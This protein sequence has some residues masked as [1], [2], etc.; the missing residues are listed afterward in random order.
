MIH[1]IQYLSLFQVGRSYLSNSSQYNDSTSK[2]NQLEKMLHDIPQTDHDDQPGTPGGCVQYDQRKTHTISKASSIS[3]LVQVN[4]RE[5]YRSIYLRANAAMLNQIKFR[6]IRSNITGSLLF[7]I[8]HGALW[9]Y[10]RI[11]T[12]NQHSTW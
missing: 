7:R 9:K 11:R 1:I 6:R 8:G 5:Q 3:I 10:R 4:V 12:Q 2:T